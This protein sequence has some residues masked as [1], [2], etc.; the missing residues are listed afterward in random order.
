V[1]VGHWLE[2]DAAELD[3]RAFALWVSNPQNA[4]AYVALVSTW[5]SLKA[6]APL[7]LPSDAEC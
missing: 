3:L 1:A 2:S 7:T 4:A 6:G 5:P